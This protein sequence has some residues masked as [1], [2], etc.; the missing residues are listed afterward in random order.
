MDRQKGA[1]RVGYFQIYLQT[2]R[3]TASPVASCPFQTGLGSAQKHD[4]L[5]GNCPSPFLA[6]FF[7]RNVA[8]G[9]WNFDVQWCEVSP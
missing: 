5:I 8:K 2:L 4:S 3:Y 7:L 6:A 9:E 1:V